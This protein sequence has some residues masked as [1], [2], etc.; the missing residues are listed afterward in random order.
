MLT[1]DERLP[2]GRGERRWTAGELDQG[3]PV[4]DPG[5]MET[6]V[7][8]VADPDALAHSVAALLADPA[9]GLTPAARLRWEGALTACELLAGRAPT[10]AG[11]EFGASVA[12]SL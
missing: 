6:D 8:P 12:A 1:V 4:P 7:R 9:A 3:A 10:L 11:D 2:A 5:G